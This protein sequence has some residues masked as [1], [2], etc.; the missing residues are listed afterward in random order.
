MTLYQEGGIMKNE[1][2]DSNMPLGRLRRVKDFLPAPADLAISK[3]TKKITISLNKFSIDF[4]KRQAEQHHTKYQRM[5][6]ELVDRYVF[7]YSQ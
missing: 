5:I 1:R 3:E 6:W 7:Q 2:A 4:F